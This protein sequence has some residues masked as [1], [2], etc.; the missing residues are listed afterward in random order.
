MAHLPDWVIERLR[1]RR[2]EPGLEQ[3]EAEVIEPVELAS[4][5][6]H[7]RCPDPDC[8][9][10][11]KVPAHEV[12]DGHYVLPG[13]YVGRYVH[14]GVDQRC[15]IGGAWISDARSIIEIREENGGRLK[16]AAHP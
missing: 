3:E 16:R 12:K 14:P 8:G 13:H 5:Y 4:Y 9:T 2:G 1:M 10:L 7:V 11:V 6:T 15:W